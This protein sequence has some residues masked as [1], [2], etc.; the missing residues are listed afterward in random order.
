MKEYKTNGGNT[1]ANAVVVPAPVGMVHSC[2][3]GGMVDG[4]GIRYVLFLA[5]CKLRCKYCHNPDAWDIHAGKPLSVDEILRDIGKYKTYLDFSG[6]G[7]TVTGGEPLTQPEFL[8]DFFAACKARGWHTALETSGHTTSDAAENVLAF[9]DLILLDI[10]AFD[11]E[12]HRNVTGACNRR[13]LDFLR[14]CEEMEKTVWV[15]YVLVP[16]LTDDAD[17]IQDMA[18][19]LQSFFCIK[20][21]DVLPFHKTGE[22]KWADL[23]LPYTLG[24]TLPPSAEAVSKL[25]DMFNRKLLLT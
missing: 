16:G 23:G 10:K 5:G 12:I 14:L 7:V 6:G 20:K 17:D 9:T 18:D 2:Y 15:R 1:A 3:M 4:P 21:I 11:A 22:Y 24:D 13:V 25:Q 8:A 19:F